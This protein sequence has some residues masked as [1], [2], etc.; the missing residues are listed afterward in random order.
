[1]VD[2]SALA[3]EDSWP[4]IKLAEGNLPVVAGREE[5][6]G[7]E[8]EGVGGAQWPQLLCQVYHGPQHQDPLR[9]AREN[10]PLVPVVGEVD[11]LLLPAAYPVSLLLQPLTGVDGQLTYHILGILFRLC[12]Y[13]WEGNYHPR[14]PID[15]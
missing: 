11:R 8:R 5:Q 15:I 7:D 12:R 14:T 4:G 9:A 13:S 6:G 2:K 10:G 1:M 3:H